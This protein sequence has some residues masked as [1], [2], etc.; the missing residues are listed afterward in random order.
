M[1]LAKEL[2]EALHEWS[3]IYM[4]RSGRDFKLFMDETGLSFSQ[5][6]ILMRL[7]HRGSCN[8]CE[9]G[10]QLGVTNAAISQSIDRL[11]NLDLIERTENPDDRR[12]KQ[13]ALAPKGQTLIEKSI[14]VRCQWIEALTTS[15]T[16]EQQKITF[17]AITWLT[18][19]A[20]A[21]KE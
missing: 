7:Y 21:T 4:R 9:L 1:S 20:Q 17:S 19:A 10:A 15:L 2:T 11:V 6:T 8:V 14:E 5:L 16:P 13:L 12:A 3:E 18:E